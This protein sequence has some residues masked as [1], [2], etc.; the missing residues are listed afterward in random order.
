MSPIEV[1]AI[2]NAI[3][4]GSN[5]WIRE[6]MGRLVALGDNFAHHCPVEVY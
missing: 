2:P 1:I 4:C 6:Y 5:K 3:E